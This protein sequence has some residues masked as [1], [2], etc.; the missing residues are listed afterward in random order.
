MVVLSIVLRDLT[1][2]LFLSFI[3]PIGTA[4]HRF[5]R[6][7]KITFSIGIEVSENLLRSIVN[8]WSFKFGSKR[9]ELKVKV[10]AFNKGVAVVVVKLSSITFSVLD[11]LKAANLALS[12]A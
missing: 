8:I 1:N 7:V 2:F 10:A 6:S 12:E 4:K 3:S 5:S 9:Q 11:L